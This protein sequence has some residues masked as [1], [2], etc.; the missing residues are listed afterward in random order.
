LIIQKYQIRENPL[1]D[2]I[3][4]SP[5]K[6]NQY[7]NAILKAFE[8]YQKGSKRTVLK[9]TDF[10]VPFIFKTKRM[11]EFSAQ[12]EPMTR[13]L[14]MEAV[15]A[16]TVRRFGTCVD[17]IF[18]KVQKELLTISYQKTFNE[19]WSVIQRESEQHPEDPKSLV[20]ATASLMMLN[21]FGEKSSR[22]A[23]EILTSSR[24]QMAIDFQVGNLLYVFNR[25]CDLAYKYVDHPVCK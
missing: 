20:A 8:H 3:I 5:E 22:P 4:V 17:T 10:Y 2:T 16:A 9:A 24:H 19:Y 15:R 25:G 12:Y 21:L 23:P 1:K 13:A 11:E 14:F 6:N 18:E 7:V